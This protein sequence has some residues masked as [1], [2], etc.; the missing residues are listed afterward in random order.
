MPSRQNDV[1]VNITAEQ[2]VSDVLQRLVD[3][4][5]SFTTAAAKT[6]AALAEAGGMTNPLAGQMDSLA[7]SQ[8]PVQEGFRQ[9]EASAD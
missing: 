9:T 8:G 5:A 2:N 4:L 3:D 7:K 6:T 1:Q